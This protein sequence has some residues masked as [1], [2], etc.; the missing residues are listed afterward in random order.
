MK[1][2]IFFTIASL[3]I[4]CAGC[5]KSEQV[6]AYISVQSFALNTDANEG[7]NSTKI[8]DVWAYSNDVFLGAFTLPTEI[9]V[10][11]EGD[12]KITLFA[13]IRNNGSNATPTEYFHYL[14]FTV[15]KKL[16]A[17]KTEIINPVTTYDKNLTFRWIE[18]FESNSS[19]F[20]KNVDQYDSTSVNVT[21]VDVKYGKKCALLKVDKKYPVMAVTTQTPFDKMPTNSRVYLEMDYKCDVPIVVEFYGLNP[22]SNQ[23][24]LDAVTFK[25][26]SEWN[27]VYINFTKNITNNYAAYSYVVTAFLP[28]DAAGQFTKDKGEA[29]VDNLKLIYPK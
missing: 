25:E 19:T 20:N 21:A 1:N 16:T 15:T 11:S 14:P 8:L 27:K 24:L 17:G 4:F 5:D 29:R 9:P 18:D 13:G 12:T 2:I 7:A 6:P 22:S 10:L 3:S 26:K 28:S 23:K